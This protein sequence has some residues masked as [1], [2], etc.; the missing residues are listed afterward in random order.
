[1]FRLLNCN[2]LLLRFFGLFSVRETFLRLMSEN[3]LNKTVVDTAVPL[4]GE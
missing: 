2:R 1:M 3:L 4:D